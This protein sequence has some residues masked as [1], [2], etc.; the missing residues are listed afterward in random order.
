MEPFVYDQAKMNQDA[1]A[2]IRI[3]KNPTPS[4]GAGGRRIDPFKDN[5][6][7]AKNKGANGGAQKKNPIHRLFKCDIFGCEQTFNTK[8]SLKRHFK[9]HYVKKLKCKFCSKV[10]GLEQYRR[11]HEHTHTGEKP[12]GC[13]ECP[14]VFR[15]RGKLS[16]HRNA[17]HSYSLRPQKDGHEAVAE[18]VLPAPGRPQLMEE[19]VITEVVKLT[20]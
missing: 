7:L 20:T 9:K 15:Q 10:F 18:Q 19:Q 3:P 13:S 6:Q 8:F 1:E 4:S 17:M 16:L 2:I 5:E 14:M 12:Y 11:E